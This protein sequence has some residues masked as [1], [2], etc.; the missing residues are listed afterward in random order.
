MSVTTL[1]TVA[2]DVNRMLNASSGT[3]ITGF[4]LVAW[5]IDD[6]LNIGT[7]ALTNTTHKDSIV[8]LKRALASLEGRI[9]ETETTQ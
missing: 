4:V 6:R 8:A 5:P 3:P 9:H 1:Q 7:T 2:R